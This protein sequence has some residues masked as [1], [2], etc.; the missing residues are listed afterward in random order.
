MLRFECI[1][2]IPIDYFDEL[3]KIHAH[4]FDGDLLPM[5]KLQS[6]KQLL[7]CLAIRN[8]QLIGFK[9][10]YEADDGVFYSWLGGVHS[11]FRGKGIAS[12][13]MKNQH[14][15]ILKLGYTTVRTI[16][17]NNRKAMLITNL[18]HD[19]DVI[20]TFTDAKGKH[21]IILEKILE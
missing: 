16:G 2:G 11:D 12:E 13:L 4:V 6:K 3:Q 10:G 9:L 21:K 20:S 19:F 1:Q 17:R 18:K 7:C 5:E 8:Q 15:F 14:A